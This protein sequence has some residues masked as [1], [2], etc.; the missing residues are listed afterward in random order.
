MM[1]FTSELYFDQ[2][3]NLENVTFSLKTNYDNPGHFSSLYFDLSNQPDSVTG[4]GPKLNTPP[5]L[6]DTNFAYFIDTR[7]GGDVYIT[8]QVSRLTENGQFTE[9]TLGRRTR[10]VGKDRGA[11]VQNEKVFLAR[12]PSSNFR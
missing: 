1:D 5:V 9:M 3:Y 4:M 7:S 12:L 6:G 2:N 11:S 10:R 8:L